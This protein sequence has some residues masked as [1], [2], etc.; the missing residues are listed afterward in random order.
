M[1][2][3]ADSHERPTGS[4]GFPTVGSIVHG[5]DHIGRAG[6]IGVLRARLLAS[7]TNAG[8]TAVVGPPRIGKSSL[9]YHTFMRDEVRAEHPRLLPV[10][11]NLRT[12]TSAEHLFRKL[13]ADVWDLLEESGDDTAV[14]ATER[15]YRRVESTYGDWQLL[16]DS[17]QRFLQR[18]R[19][20][21]YKVVLILDEFDSAR[22]VFK[23]HP[24]GFQS[25]RELAYN[26][27]WRIGLVTTSRREL[28]EIVDNTDPAESTFP[29]I[30]REVYLSCFDDDELVELI[31]RLPGHCDTPT[32]LHKILMELT[33]GHP[34]LA[35]A[36]LERLGDM[37]RPVTAA[38]MARAVDESRPQ[39]HNYYRDLEQLLS[40]D[41]RFQTLLEILI[42]PQITAT[43]E[44][45]E[46][47]R[48]QGLIHSEGE[49][50]RA[51][52]E[53]F[54]AHL[55]MVHRRSDYWHTWSHLE[56]SLRHFVEDKLVERYGRDWAASLVLKQPTLTEI[57]EK[58]QQAQQKEQH[59]FGALAS[60]SLLDFTYPKDL[61]A[62]MAKH[63]D[64]FGPVLGKQKGYW[65]ERFDVLAKVRNPI[66]HNR[67]NALTP[68][69]R[70]LFQ[71]YCAELLALL[72]TH[73]AP[74]LPPTG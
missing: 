69:D 64:L 34:Y 59:T 9:A 25:L 12:Q 8:A 54:A 1:T 61:Y 17:T 57:I 6:E 4:R 33:G 71:A 38:N 10:W 73:P 20:H 29:G 16:Q 56:R 24:G 31:S 60:R 43:P 26:P 45:V 32:E 74:E 42:G 27:D 23:T 21:G 18:V 68:A 66:A 53:H 2:S 28:R 72:E 36:V 19:R 5:E 67:M 49:R 70:S 35:S 47:L 39:I 3:T 55:A 41:G 50:Y 63:W 46:L 40:G 65:A 62:L 52:S 44:D 22:D 51:F 14:R 58:C 11:I 30:F 48:H 13:T 7:A 15:H 37:G